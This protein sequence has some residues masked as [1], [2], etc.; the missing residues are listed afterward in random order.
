VKLRHR[1]AITFAA[2]SFAV[3]FASRVTTIAS[4]SRVQQNELDDGL[5][6][7]AREESKE[8]ALVGRKALELEFAE[9]AGGSET[10][11]LE[12]LVTYGALYRADGSLVADTPSFAHAPRLDEIGMPPARSLGSCFDFDFHGKRLRGVLVDVSS[13]TPGEAKYLLLAASRRDMDDDAR[14]LLAVG[15]WVFL[16]FL[17]ISLAIGWWLGRRMT[18][19][20][21][22]LARAAGRVTAGELGM[23]VAPAATRDEEVAAL[24]HALREMLS[25]L[26]KLIATE[27]RFASH[28]AHE[29]RSPLTALR[30]EIELA[31]RRERSAADYEATLRG[32]LE[33]T[34]RLIDLA[35]DLL[36]VART[37]SRGT[38]ES[39]HETVTVAELVADAVAASSG[40]TASKAGVAVDCADAAVRGSNVALVRMLRNLIDNALVHGANEGG[41]RI[42][43]RAEDDR[44]RISVEDDGPGV[45]AEDRDRIFEPFHRGERS[46]EDTGAGLGLGI[47]R[48]VARRHG[49]DV[50][51]DSERNPTRFVVRLPAVR[52]V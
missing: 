29:L 33:D 20:L 25:R 30:G 15:W 13:Q 48:E 52:V 41:V 26:D 12:Q 3:L 18:L 2:A 7:R 49:G 22:T 27:R 19:G 46:R 9:Q 6:T 4:F 47:A 11:P 1:F 16:A 5:R 45:P 28:A 42:T 17:P 35:E 44:V 36:V 24:G 21:E 10:D 23:E 40:R 34:N 14:R 31:L 38:D 32:A 51:I 8:V 50:F 39:D 37:Q 43:A